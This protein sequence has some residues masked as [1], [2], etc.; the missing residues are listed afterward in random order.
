MDLLGW[1]YIHCTHLDINIADLIFRPDNGPAHHRGEY[2]RREIAAGVSTFHELKRK[3]F[4]LRDWWF[5]GLSWVWSFGWVFGSKLTPVPL[6]QTITFL[7]WSSIVVSVYIRTQSY[8]Y[9][10]RNTPK[11]WIENYGK[12]TIPHGFWLMIVFFYRNANLWQIFR[13]L[14]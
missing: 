3:W 10:L 12:E 11:Y 5:K 1:I 7:P 13:N 2:K 6:S 14:H 4:L 8:W 9:Y